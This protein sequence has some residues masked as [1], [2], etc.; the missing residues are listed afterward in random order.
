MKRP[1]HTGDVAEHPLLGFE[2]CDECKALLRDGGHIVGRHLFDCSQ[3]PDCTPR[4]QVTDFIP[5]AQRCS[6][7]GARLTNA[8]DIAIAHAAAASLRHAYGLLLEQ[9]NYDIDKRTRQIVTA[10][11]VGVRALAE[12]ERPGSEHWTRAVLLIDQAIEELEL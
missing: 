11:L 6:E 4:P 10:A 7:L 9:P 1:L 5:M 2:H 12:T 8:M 3:T